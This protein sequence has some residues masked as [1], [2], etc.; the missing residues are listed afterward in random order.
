MSCDLPA[1]GSFPSQRFVRLATERTSRL[2]KAAKTEK[3]DSVASFGYVGATNRRDHLLIDVDIVAVPS[4]DTVSV[5]KPLSLLSQ[6]ESARFALSNISK[7]KSE[8]PS[9]SVL[10]SKTI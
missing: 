4:T 1:G 7:P 2:I 5:S 8:W 6:E 3:Q 10:F 9:R